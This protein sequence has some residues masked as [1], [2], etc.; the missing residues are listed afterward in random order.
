M[1]GPPGASPVK[2][3]ICN[4][5]LCAGDVESK[6]VA[7]ANALADEGLTVLFAADDGPLREKLDARVKYLPIE[8]VHH[9]LTHAAHDLSHLLREQ[10]P[11][12]IHSYDDTCALAAAIAVKASKVGCARVLTHD[13]RVFR[14]VPSFISGPITRHC[15][16]RFIAASGDRLQDL[17]KLGVPGEKILRIPRFPDPGATASAPSG[18]AGDPRAAARD[19]IQAYRDLLAARTP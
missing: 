14:H 4:G 1:G 8:N 6:A 12:V 9:A 2:V 3:L 18:E 13:E 17:K 19:T 16:D 7:L 15:A 11:D 10:R 5:S